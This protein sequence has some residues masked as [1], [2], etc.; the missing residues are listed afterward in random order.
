M[1]FP[2][3]VL[4]LAAV[5]IATPA[6]SNAQVARP[7]CGVDTLR[8]TYALHCHRVQH[9]RWGRATEGDR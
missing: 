6:I 3:I 1:K 7:F 4:A 2:G 9:R 5:T 8:G